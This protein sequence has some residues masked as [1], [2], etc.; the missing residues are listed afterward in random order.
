ME[1]IFI[2]FIILAPISFLTLLEIIVLK[3]SCEKTLKYLKLLKGIEIFFF[4]SSNGVIW[5]IIC[6]IIYFTILILIFIRRL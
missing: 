4:L 3:E 2:L 1:L 5:L 6:I